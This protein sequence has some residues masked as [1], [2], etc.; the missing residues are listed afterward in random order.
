MTWLTSLS[1][2]RFMYVEKHT[3]DYNPYE[4][5]LAERVPAID[6]RIAFMWD[7]RHMLKLIIVK[8]KRSVMKA[9]RNVRTVQFTQ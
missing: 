8:L 5:H 1:V 9:G 3:A 4:H 7:K 6:R 2:H